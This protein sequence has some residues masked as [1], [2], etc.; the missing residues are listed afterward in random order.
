MPQAPSFRLESYNQQQQKPPV[1]A[2]DAASSIHKAVTKLR[3]AV[4]EQQELVTVLANISSQ[5]QESVLSQ[6]LPDLAVSPLATADLSTQ[7]LSHCST[8]GS[9]DATAASETLVAPPGISEDQQQESWQPEA[10]A[11]AAAADTAPD[12]LQPEEIALLMDA[13]TSML[14]QELQL[15]VSLLYLGCMAMDLS[16]ICVCEHSVCYLQFVLQPSMTT[17]YLYVL[18]CHVVGVE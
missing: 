5:Y 14:E 2:S 8:P 11:A 18:Q 17:M 13:V 15:M 6:Q 12:K 1:T 4:T 7:E 3:E 10:A 16:A 9:A